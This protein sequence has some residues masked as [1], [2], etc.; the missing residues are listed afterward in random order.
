MEQL[1]K[2]FTELQSDSTQIKKEQDK[3]LTSEELDALRGYPFEETNTKNSTNISNNAGIAIA[4]IT[5]ILFFGFM[6]FRII[7]GF[8]K[9]V[10]DYSYATGEIKNIGRNILNDPEKASKMTEDEKKQI[11]EMMN[12]FDKK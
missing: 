4:I 7:K 6:F 3:Q 8:K 2:V 5:G 11:N 9:G 1:A 12:Y 10:K